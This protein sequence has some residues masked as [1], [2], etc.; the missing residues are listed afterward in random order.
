[1]DPRRLSAG[2]WIAAGGAIVLL[3]SLF[4]PWYSVGSKDLT[5]WEAMSVNDVL[6]AL[7]SVGTLLA[8]ATTASRR[9]AAVPVV[10]TVLATIAGFVALVLTVWRIADPAP[11]GE[12]TRAAGAWL[13]LLG[14]AGIT[15]GAAVG[16]RDE[17]PARRTPAAE[18]AAAAAS[19]ERAELLPLPP[20]AGEPA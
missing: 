18:R 12:V 8:M 16:M 10:F 15:V 20:D 3:V 17:G 7:I 4:L 13:A 9:R 6:L 1:V 2:E 11:A 19:L 5:G 14:A